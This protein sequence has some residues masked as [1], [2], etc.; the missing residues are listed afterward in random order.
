M[1][2]VLAISSVL[3]GV[4]FLAGCGQQ[5]VSQTQP[6]TPAP[7]AKQPAT[8]PPVATQPTT[9]T[10]TMSFDACGNLNK[11]QKESWYNEF[12]SLVK[13]D[14]QQNKISNDNFDDVKDYAQ[15]CY[16]K[17]GN[18]V[19]AT[20]T[21]AYCQKGRVMKFDISSQKLTIAKFIDQKEGESCYFAP[22]KFGKQN[23]NAF[24][25]SRLSGD[26]GGSATFYFEYNFVENTVK[27][28]K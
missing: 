24:E 28:K 13:N 11:Y 14:F 25:L 20:F 3:L 8:N 17:D 22:E 18:L 26:A 7:V 1:K 2:K 23:G 12:I 21:G 9:A 27:D 16:S 5:P 19:L 4:V 15:I 6:T 10:A